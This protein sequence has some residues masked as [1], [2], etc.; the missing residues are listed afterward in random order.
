[1]IT[2]RLLYDYFG[3]FYKNKYKNWFKNWCELYM[4]SESQW[5]VPATDLRE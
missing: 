5:W 2:L 1:M 4:Y 3:F